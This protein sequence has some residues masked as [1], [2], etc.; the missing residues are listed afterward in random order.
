SMQC[1]SL[2]PSSKVL[3]TSMLLLDSSSS[4][5]LYTGLSK[6][7]GPQRFQSPV[8]NRPNNNQSPLNQ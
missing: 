5:N 3:H 8:D 7:S 1:R 2:V 4:G 6:P